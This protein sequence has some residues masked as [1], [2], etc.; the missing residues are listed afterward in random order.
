VI[1]DAPRKRGLNLGSQGP[2]PLS[3]PA[4][5]AYASDRYEIVRREAGAAGVMRGRI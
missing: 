4:V 5:H 2:L 1:R 3:D